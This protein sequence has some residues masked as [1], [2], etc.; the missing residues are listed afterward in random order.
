MA[1]AAIRKLKSDRFWRWMVIAVSQSPQAVQAAEK[2]KIRRCRKGDKKAMRKM[3]R[4]WHKK[5]V[6]ERCY[7]R[8]HEMVEEHRRACIEAVRVPS[9][10][11]NAPPCAAGNTHE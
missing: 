3:S 8:M 6:A 11:L 7:K 5:G 1:K 4:S 2:W 9:E 10:I